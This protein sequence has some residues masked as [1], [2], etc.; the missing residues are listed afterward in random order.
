MGYCMLYSCKRFLIE[1]MRADNPRIFWGFTISQLVS[2]A[3]LIAALCIF[4]IKADE[5]KKRVSAGSK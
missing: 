4:K 5:W 1:F 2:A 3:V